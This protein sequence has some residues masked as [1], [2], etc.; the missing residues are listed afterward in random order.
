LGFHSDGNIFIG[1][2]YQL[3]EITEDGYHDIKAQAKFVKR[4]PIM[5]NFHPLRLDCLLIWVCTLAC[6]TSPSP[7]SDMKETTIPSMGLTLEI[8]AGWSGTLQQDGSMLYAPVDNLAYRGK[9]TLQ[10]WPGV[11]VPKGVTVQPI[12]SRFVLDGSLEF[13]VYE[14][15]A[16]VGGEKYRMEGWVYSATFDESVKSGMGSVR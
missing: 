1:P 16:L 8:P 14:G 3:G 13:T 12:S 10:I 6:R 4:K 11:S 15:E 5:N 2:S 9:N 7:Y